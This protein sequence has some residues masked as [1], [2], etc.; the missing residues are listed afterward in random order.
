M[1]EDVNY[2]NNDPT[3]SY[4]YLYDN[5]PQDRKQIIKDLKV[6]NRAHFRDAAK[7]INQSYF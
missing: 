6:N 5:Y 3:Y 4:K 1:N 7:T 2:L